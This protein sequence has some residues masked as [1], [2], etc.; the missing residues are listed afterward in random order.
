MKPWQIILYIAAGVALYFGTRDKKGEGESPTENPPP[1]TG[2]LPRG[3]RNNNPGNIKLSSTPWKGKI[4]PGEN[5]DGTFEQFKTM[6]YGTR[7]MIKVLQTYYTRYGLNTIKTLLARYAPNSENPTSNY[8]DFVVKKSGYGPNAPL[9][10]SKET[11]KKII[12]P[13][14]DFE[15][16]VKNALSV[17]DFDKGWNL[18]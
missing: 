18:V 4:P 17:A 10:M 8:V 7:A 6:D 12:L 14:A 5:T 9:D 3:L 15:N 1:Y 13:M 2:T 11:L 16:G